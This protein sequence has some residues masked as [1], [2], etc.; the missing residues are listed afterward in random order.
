MGIYNHGERS[1]C[2][3]DKGYYIKSCFLYQSID[4]HTKTYKGEQQ[5]WQN[6][7]KPHSERWNI[8]KVPVDHIRDA[9]LKSNEHTD[10][11]ITEFMISYV[12]KNT[13]S[14]R[15]KYFWSLS[16]Y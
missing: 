1:S 6:P 12:P 16:K 2:S 9:S 4:Y 3:H 14:H 10:R 13:N 5:G 11:Y 15:H 7:I 8:F